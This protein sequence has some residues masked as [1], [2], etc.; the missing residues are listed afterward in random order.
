MLKGLCKTFKLTAFSNC[1]VIIQALQKSNSQSSD[2]LDSLFDDQDP[3]EISN[4]NLAKETLASYSSKNI[5]CFITK[6]SQI[7]SWQV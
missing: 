2:S 6:F 3:P 5:N 7:I 1:F 4:I